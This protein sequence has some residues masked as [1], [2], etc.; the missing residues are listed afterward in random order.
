MHLNLNGLRV[1]NDLETRSPVRP[2]DCFDQ[3]TDDAE[4]VA[5]TDEQ[6]ATH[7]ALSEAWLHAEPATLLSPLLPAG[8]RSRDPTHRTITILLIDDDAIDVIAIRRSFWQLKIANPL[9][10]ARNGLEAL[11]I[12][13]GDNSHAKLEAPYLILL[14]LNMPRMGGIEFL[15]ELRRDPA[16]RRTL[17]FVM[18]T[19]TADEDRE[20]AYEKNIAGY[21]M[22]PGPGDGFAATIGALES[23]WRAI[24]FPD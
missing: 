5:R 18:T 22:K 2:G 4:P 13:R 12:L 10:V 16:L 15:D 6:F 21:V 24:E 1:T 11:D 17:V 14:D 8:L 23:Y 19:S 7:G 20:R 3:A 9:V